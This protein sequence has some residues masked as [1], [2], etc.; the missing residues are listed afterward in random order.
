MVNILQFVVFIAI[1]WE[2]LTPAKTIS[3]LKSL[4][5]IALLEFLPTDKIDDTFFD[6]FDIKNDFDAMN[7]MGEMTAKVN[8]V[9]LLSM[10]L[11]S[12]YLLLSSFSSSA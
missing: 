6:W 3:F 2:N 12:S 5:T 4:K 1:N 9:S 10:S 11:Q 7:L 8:A